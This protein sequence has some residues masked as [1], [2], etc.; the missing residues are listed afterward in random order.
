[1]KH[2]DIIIVGGGP[3]GLTAAL[4]AARSG[5]QVLVIEKNNLGGQIAYTPVVENYPGMPQMSGA[6]YAAA[7][8]EQA[9]SFGVEFGFEEATQLIPGKPHT[10]HTDFD[11][12]TCS[13]VILA[14]GAEHRPLGVEGEEDLVG[15]GISYCSTCD[16]AFYAGRDVAVIGG[17]NTAVQEALYLSDLCS[18]VTLIH[19]RN[20]LRADSITVRRIPE[21]NNLR[22]LTPYTVHEIVQTEGEVSGLVLQHTETKELLTV[23]THGI[24]VA[25]GQK[26][27]S[28]AFAPLG[29]CLDSGYF[30]AGETTVTA[31][32]GVFV[33]GDCRNKK[34]RQLTTACADGTNAAMAAC[35]WLDTL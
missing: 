27:Q 2:Y 14:I 24:F 3:A 17:G 28:E 9:E 11:S 26:P 7:L 29:L 13:A 4:Y 15:S 34:I 35:D 18:S 1:M 5:K 8:A 25:I 30:N 6:A 23:P 31:V 21:K 22:L 12:Y 16:G 32:D 20:E 33:A 10:L 19:R